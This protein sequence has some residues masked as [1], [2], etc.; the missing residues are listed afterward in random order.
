MGT[1]DW[2]FNT[3]V[4]KNLEPECKYLEEA[5][6]SGAIL[7]TGCDGPETKLLITHS[8]VEI[9]EVPRYKDNKTKKEKETV[10]S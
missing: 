6:K 10:L 9:Y 7:Y 8:Q 4:E 3:V 2:L 5:M 1:Y